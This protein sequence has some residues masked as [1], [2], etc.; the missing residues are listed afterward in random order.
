MGGLGAAMSG[1][2]Y[3]PEYVQALA[4]LAKASAAVRRAGSVAP[5]LVGGAVV[6]FDTASQIVSGDFDFVSGDDDKFAE[7]LVALGFEQGD[8]RAIRRGTFL[9][10]ALG[11]GVELVSGAYF[12]G[13]GDRE[14]IR[15]VRV[16]G[17][18]VSM[19]PTEDLIADRLGQWVASDRK[20][21]NVLNQA[22]TLFQLAEEPDL[23]YVDKRIRE[24]TDGD[25]SL[26]SFSRLCNENPDLG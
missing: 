6:E 14:R 15:L 7:A 4:L 18:E 11:I 9:H 10:P 19:A 22:V 26:E 1:S 12:D 3:R 25:L 17:A 2:L 24:E 21:R 8:G 20:D 5:V 16:A 13:R 23:S